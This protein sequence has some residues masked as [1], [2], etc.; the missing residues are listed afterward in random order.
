MKQNKTIWAFALA[1]IILPVA[2]YAVITWYEQKIQQLPVIGES[3]YINGK[4]TKHQI[5]DFQLT[6][7]DGNNITPETWKNKIVVCNFFFTR[8]PSICPKMTSNIK[9]VEEKYKNDD[10]IIFNS[11]SVDPEGDNVAQLNSYAHLYDIHS[12]NWQL[13]TGNKKEIYKLARNSFL[14]VAAEGDGGP[15]D[16]IHS[17]KVTLVDKQQR[18]RGYYDGTSEKEIK[19]LITDIKK[20]KNE[21]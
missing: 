9:K 17:D 5:G 18:I 20:L 2:A 3:E 16:F 8:C 13:L 19:E 12:S 4:L 1:A 14:V 10:E 7:Q 11:F 6:N 15:K 21:N